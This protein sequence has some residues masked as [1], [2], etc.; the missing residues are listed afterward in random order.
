[1]KI[2]VF[3]RTGFHHTYFINRLQKHF[4]I[5]CVVRESYPESYKQRYIFISGLKNIFKKNG[6]VRIKDDIFIKKFCEMY[7]AG[8]RYHPALK[9]YLKSDYDVVIRKEGTKYINIK[10]GEINSDDFRLFLKETEPDIVAVLGSSI[11][12]THIISVPR[13]TMVNIHSGLSPYYRGTW[14]YGWPLVNGEPEYIGVT[15]HH[16]NPGIDTGDIIC[17]TKPVLE[18]NDDL[19]AIFL[20]II[21][22]GTGLVIKTIE[23]YIETGSVVSYKQPSNVGKQYFTRDFNADAARLCLANLKEGIIEKYNLNKSARDSAVKLYGYVPP[24]IYR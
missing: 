5:A 22:E 16:I 18:K 24:L 8:F 3:T 14:S 10:C 23:E 17:Q 20:K 4:D 2:A 15:V 9:E 13:I 6:I 7:S 12:K 11:I 21:C 19:N 1:M